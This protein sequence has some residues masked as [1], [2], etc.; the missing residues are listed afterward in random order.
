MQYPHVNSVTNTPVTF[1]GV[2]SIRSKAPIPGIKYV[3]SYP[4]LYDRNTLPGE[5][6]HVFLMDH[7]LKSIRSIKITTND[8]KN[9]HRTLEKQYHSKILMGC[10]I[11]KMLY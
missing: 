6:R 11:K 8:P 5:I 2:S 4:V 3:M 9:P 1:N 10:F 7:E